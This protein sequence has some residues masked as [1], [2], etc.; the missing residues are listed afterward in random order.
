MALAARHQRP[1]PERRDPSAKRW[2]K[3]LFRGRDEVKVKSV[4]SPRLVRDTQVEM[5]HASGSASSA[6]PKTR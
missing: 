2:R 4:T 3:F 1:L 5:M 6:E